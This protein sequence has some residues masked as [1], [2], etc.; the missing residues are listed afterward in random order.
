MLD[1]CNE[2]PEEDVLSNFLYNLFGDYKILT[3][4]DRANLSKMVSDVPGFIEKVIQSLQQDRILLFQ[5]L[6]HATSVN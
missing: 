6:N 4:T 1:R 5:K 2:C 3:N